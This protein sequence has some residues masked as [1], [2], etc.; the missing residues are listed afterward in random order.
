VIGL[1]IHPEAGGGAE[2]AGEE[3]GGLGGDGALAADNL[4][5]A[6]AARMSN[7]G[8]APSSAYQVGLAD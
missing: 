8:W 2:G 5:D 7:S 6:Q 3:D 1:Q 4:T